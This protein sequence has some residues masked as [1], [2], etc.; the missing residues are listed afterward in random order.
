LTFEP[1]PGARRNREAVILIAGDGHMFREPAIAIPAIAIVLIT[2][3]HVT[4]SSHA[5]I[6]TADAQAIIARDAFGCQSPWQVIEGR[7]CYKLPAGT[8]VIIVSGDDFFACVVWPGT[9]RCKWIAR[10][11]L[12]KR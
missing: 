7:D 1:A 3:F 4:A 10:D 6:A 5:A 8:E 11:V 2:S 12:R 9:Q